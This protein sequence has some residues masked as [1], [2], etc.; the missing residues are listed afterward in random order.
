MTEVEQLIAVE[1][2]PTQLP[3]DVT[4]PKPGE[5]VALVLWYRQDDGGEPIYRYEIPLAGLKK[6]NLYRKFES[7]KSESSCS[8]F[9]FSYFVECR[10]I[11]FDAIEPIFFVLTDQRS[12]IHSF[13]II[14]N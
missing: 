1:G 11:Q 12:I 8:E 2:H 7:I 4:P 13:H 14:R 5:Q 3:C 6:A 10:H 9:G